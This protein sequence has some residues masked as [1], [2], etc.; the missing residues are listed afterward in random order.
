MPDKEKPVTSRKL[1][2][3]VMLALGAFL[4]FGV[5][6]LVFFAAESLFDL[7]VWDEFWEMIGQ[8]F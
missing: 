4:F 6:A 5:V 3:L 8:K 1:S 2:C 7:G